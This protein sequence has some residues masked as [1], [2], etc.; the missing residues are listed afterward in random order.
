[1]KLCSQNQPIS[2]LIAALFPDD[3]NGIWASQFFW[4]VNQNLPDHTRDQYCQ[5]GVALLRTLQV[6][7]HHPSEA[8]PFA[9]QRSNF[10][11][12]LSLWVKFPYIRQDSLIWRS[13]IKDH[14][15][16][17]FHRYDNATK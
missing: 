17:A 14:L 5:V 8:L 12:W 3:R 4:F 7:N 9:Q 2:G 13:T 10:T 11:P 1:M 15:S 6:R 16:V